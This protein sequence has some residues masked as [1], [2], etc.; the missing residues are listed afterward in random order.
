MIVVAFWNNGK[1]VLLRKADKIVG[2]ERTSLE[3]AIGRGER[4]DLEVGDVIQNKFDSEFEPKTFY[5]PDWLEKK[6]SKEKQQKRRY[7]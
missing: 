2:Y 6:F 5:V 4:I 3:N 1:T 7:N